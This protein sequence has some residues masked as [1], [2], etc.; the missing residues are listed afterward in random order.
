MA[1]LATKN[2]PAEAAWAM[3]TGGRVLLGSGCSN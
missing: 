3:G 2:E 1:L